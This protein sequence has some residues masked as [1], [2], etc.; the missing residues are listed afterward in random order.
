MIH[1]MYSELDGPAGVTRR[2]EVKGH[3]GYAPAG[4]DIVC[5]G[6]SILT[7]A[8]IWMAAEMDQAECTASDGPEGPRVVVT[9]HPGADP[10]EDQ[11]I[12]GSFELAKTGLALLAERYPDNLRY[13]DTSREGE[14]CMVDLQM[15][16]QGPAL[17]RE[18][19]RQAMAEG[20]MGRRGRRSPEPAAPE[21]AGA[22]EKQEAPEPR[23]APMLG[24]GEAGAFLRMIH[25]LHRR[26]AREEAEMRRYDP[27]YSFREALKSPD[28][29]RMMRM[30]G[31]RMRDAY[32]AANYDRLMESTARAV[33]R[34]V[35]NRVRERG[36]RP[37]ENGLRPTGAATTSPDVSRMSRAQREAIEREVMRGAKIRL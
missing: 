17:S 32:R 31:M 1:A 6:A 18:Q 33:E 28:M 29:R 12:N 20:T 35:V 34:G 4:Q 8:L 19:K 21:P 22:K 26:W 16:G 24:I 11:R 10:R 37:A 30:P 23:P 36:V 27:G 7:Q 5:A 3:A 25:E 13:A 15:F 2:L 14:A 9:A